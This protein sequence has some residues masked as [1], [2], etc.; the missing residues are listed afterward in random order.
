[1]GGPIGAVAMV[2]SGELPVRRGTSPRRSCSPAAEPGAEARGKQEDE[3]QCKQE[4][5]GRGASLPDGHR[6][7]GA[8][9]H[10]KGDA[11]PD[12]SHRRDRKDDAEEPGVSLRS[13]EALVHL[14]L[15][16]CAG[17][18]YASKGEI[19]GC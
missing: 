5:D 9:D 4:A 7:E 8:L 19:T 11:Q 10:G 12:E 17:R 15:T 14:G 1:M 13:V 3:P 6:R 2:I 16:S 18:R